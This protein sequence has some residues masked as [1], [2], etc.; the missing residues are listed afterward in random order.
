MFS[1]LGYGDPAPLSDVVRLNIHPLFGWVLLIPGSHLG[2]LRFLISCFH[3]K[4]LFSR[5]ALLRFRSEGF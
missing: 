5:V 3:H 2:F 1:L 4:Y